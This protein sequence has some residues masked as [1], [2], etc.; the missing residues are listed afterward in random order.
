MA[1]F[2]ICNECK[3]KDDDKLDMDSEWDHYSGLPNPKAYDREE[4]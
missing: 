1:G 3:E 4:E 2:G